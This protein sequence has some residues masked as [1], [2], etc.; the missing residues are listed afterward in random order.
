MQ[1]IHLISGVDFNGWGQDDFNILNLVSE[2]GVNE[3]IARDEIPQASFNSA[4]HVAHRR[5]KAVQDYLTQVGIPAGLVY[6][7]VFVG[8]NI[9]TAVDETTARTFGLPLMVRPDVVN[10]LSVACL[11]DLQ[12]VIAGLKRSNGAFTVDDRIVNLSNAPDRIEALKQLCLRAQ[13][14]N[15]AA[16]ANFVYVEARLNRPWSH[17]DFVRLGQPSDFWKKIKR[18]SPLRRVQ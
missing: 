14:H 2:A 10:E 6:Q 12:K 18:Q 5:E 16:R 11:G 8:F 3:A 15:A 1:K 4:L 17:S 7:S 9:G 13:E